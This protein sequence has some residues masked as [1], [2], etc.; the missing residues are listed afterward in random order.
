[1]QV[2]RSNTLLKMELAEQRQ[3]S[4]N[5][6]IRSYRNRHPDLRMAFGTDLFSYISHYVSSGRFEGRV[7]T[8]GFYI[9]TDY[10]Y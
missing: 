3:G 2:L 10:Y 8:G 4:E 5:F 7:A 9:S 6:D 1:M